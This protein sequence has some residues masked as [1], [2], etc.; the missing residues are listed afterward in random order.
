MS[1]GCMRCTLQVWEDLMVGLD[2]LALPRTLCH[3]SKKAACALGRQHLGRLLWDLAIEGKLLELGEAQVAKAVMSL[4]ELG[5]IIGSRE[6]DI[7]GF[8]GQR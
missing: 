2:F 7:F 5:M 1:F 6:L 4:H 3:R 8:L